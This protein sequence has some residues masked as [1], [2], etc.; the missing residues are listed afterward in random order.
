M[1]SLYLKIKVVYIVLLVCL[2]HSFIAVAQHPSTK[3]EI[4]VVDDEN[5]WQHV[6]KQYRGKTV[7]ICFMESIKEES[8][9]ENLE[10]VREMEIKLKGK[11]VVF[12]KCVAQSGRKNK[13]QRYQ[14]CV[15]T[16]SA[17]GM[18]DDVY[19][20]ENTL[21]VHAMA[22]DATEGHWG[23]YNADG[24]IHHPTPRKIDLSKSF[25]DQLP[26]T[27]LLQELDTVLRG[28]GHYY[29]RNADYFLRYTSLKKFASNDG[30]YKAWTLGYSSG[31]YLIYQAGDPD[32]P[33]YG[34]EEDSLYQQMKFIDGKTYIEDSVVLK[35]GPVNPKR[36]RYDYNLEPFW[37]TG[38]FSYVLD[39]KKNIITIKDN[40]GK[41]YK[42]FRIVLI[43]IDMMVVESV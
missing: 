39:K 40:H 38:R 42:R 14:E 23:I 34:R 6:L 32:Q 36:F 3:A 22:E 1:K 28:K 37:G 21:S 27:T 16:F 20:I 13:A 35:K 33:M 26:A 18:P 15:A 2:L 30:N 12:L 11:N 17:L 41:L 7:V 24:L 9:R 29:E 43:T 25:K 8:V 19:Y 10:K 4:K 31:P 5:A